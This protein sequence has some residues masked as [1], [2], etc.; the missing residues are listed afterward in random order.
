MS[1]RRDRRLATIPGV[2]EDAAQI[3]EKFLQRKI[4]T[5]NKAAA[6]VTPYNYQRVVSYEVTEDPQR[7]YL[8][9]DSY[10]QASVDSFLHDAAD[11]I[12]E[13]ASEFEKE[14]FRNKTSSLPSSYRTRID[15]DVVLDTRTNNGS[16]SPSKKSVPID[17]YKKG[18]LGKTGSVSS[19]DTEDESLSVKKGRRKKSLFTRTKERLRHAFK[20]Q[21][22]DVDEILKEKEKKLKKY[23]TKAKKKA[24]AKD[25]KA[26]SE[27]GS[28]KA[29][30]DVL[31]EVRTHTHTHIHQEVL[32]PNGSSEQ[33]MIIRTEDTTEDIEVEDEVQ[34]RHTKKRISVKESENGFGGVLGRI[35]RSFSRRKSTGAK[36]GLSASKS[37]E[38]VISQLNM[39]TGPKSTPFHRTNSEPVSEALACGRH[40]YSMNQR[41]TFSGREKAKVTEFFSELITRQTRVDGDASD[42][43]TVEGPTGKSPGGSGGNPGSSPSSP[44]VLLGSGL[45]DGRRSRLGLSGITRQDAVMAPQESFDLDLDRH[46]VDQVVCTSKGKIETRSRVIVDENL[47]LPSNVVM[48]GKDYTDHPPGKDSVPFD[49][50][51]E[52]EK[53]Q[54]YDIIA[55]KLADIADVYVESEAETPKEELTSLEKKLL[56][57]LRDKGDQINTDMNMSPALQMVKNATYS[58]FQNTV[59]KAIGHE[60][61]VKQ[62][63]MLFHLTKGAVQIAG[64]GG[65]L[66]MKIKENTLRYFEDTFAA[67]IVGQGGWDSML[68]ESDSELDIVDKK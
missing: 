7:H 65:A 5:Q 48:D 14:N 58:T 44:R 52:E 16:H 9:S 2:K 34:M 39:K 38:P 59:Q 47:K 37:V 6:G 32:H 68:E 18:Q 15:K 29:H 56:D 41:K 43:D 64:A 51:S 45:G 42:Y 10:K 61:S 8:R 13:D 22:N 24:K 20:K 1:G 17:Y 55:R 19:S 50:K 63:A 36:D 40:E 35:R 3:L 27:N 67:W 49:E 26:K 30:E 66:A 11:V 53:E 21:P 57:C 25:S 31:A 60:T 12:F 4:A 54:M 33:P 28:R 46:Q 23:R 62:I